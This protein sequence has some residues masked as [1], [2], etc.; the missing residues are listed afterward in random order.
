[1]LNSLIYAL[2]LET[3]Q[4]SYATAAALLPEIAVVQ[5]ISSPSLAYASAPRKKTESLGPAIEAKSAY[6]IDI[7][8]GEPL[9]V[10][11]IFKMRQIAS[12]AKL[13]TA[14]V[15]LDRHGLEE[16][17]TVSPNASRQQGSAMGLASGEKITVGSLLT[18]MLINSG[19]DAAVAL[20]EF[21]AGSEVLFVNRMNEKAARLGLTQTR[22]SNA[23]GFDEKGNYSTAFD[24]MRFGRAA[25]GYPFIKQTASIKKYEVA[26]ANGKIKHK[27]ES[28]NELLEN[29]HFSIVGLKTGHTPEAGES[30]VGLV[31]G[32]N[33]HDILTIVFDS[34]NRFKETKILVDWILRNYDFPQ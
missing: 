24:T 8:S 14:M 26:S 15:I 1:M 4:P 16:I 32:P 10:R 12:I 11:E 25:L 2:L 20:A 9:F 23:K 6:A 28:T 7:N 3:V 27:L 5:E 19:N 22:F 31:K 33:G 13:I 18:G 21:D 29:P 17:V 30:F 34:P